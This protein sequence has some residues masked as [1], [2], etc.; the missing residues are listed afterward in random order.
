MSSSVDAPVPGYARVA[1]QVRHF[2]AVTEYL[3]IA[4]NLRWEE[5]A[6]PTAHLSL[7]SF[8]FPDESRRTSPHL[9][10]TQTQVRLPELLVQE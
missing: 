10:D 8:Q 2:S 9:G 3:T 5:T 4:A 1:R 7:M 6:T